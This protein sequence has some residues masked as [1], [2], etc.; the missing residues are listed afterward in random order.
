MVTLKDFTGLDGCKWLLITQDNSKLEPVNLNDYIQQ[1]KDGD[2][3][4]IEW[5][6][7]PDLA[8]VCMAGT[9]A[10]INCAMKK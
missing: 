5:E 7:Q 4:M 8:S 3:Y 2:V 1:P 6:E 10:K 9:I